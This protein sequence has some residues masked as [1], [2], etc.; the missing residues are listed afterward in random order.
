MLDTCS[1]HEQVD[2]QRFEAERVLELV[3]PD[4]HFA[5]MNYRWAGAG[6]HVHT[7]GGAR[8]CGGV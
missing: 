6:A 7:C 2:A 5:L 1:I 3:P 4:G 8:A